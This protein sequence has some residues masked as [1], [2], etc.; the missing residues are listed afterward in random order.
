MPDHSDSSPP[1]KSY[2]DYAGIFL[3]AMGALLYE[4]A[5]T[6][7]FSYVIWSHFAFM[8]VSTALFGFGLSGVWLSIAQLRSWRLGRRQVPLLSILFA[9]SAAASLEIIILVPLNIGEFSQPAQWLYLLIVYASLILPFGFAGLAISILLSGSA[10]K[11]H[12][13]YFLVLRR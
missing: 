10:Q 5:L 3:L 11:V 2:A 1:D 8:I 13:L 4:I 12:K 6:R 7:I 9:L